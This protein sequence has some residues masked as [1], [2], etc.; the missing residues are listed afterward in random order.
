MAEKE[1]NI[2]SAVEGLDEQRRETLKRLIRGGAFVAPVVA[3]FAMQGVSIR[4]AHAASSAVSNGTGI[5][6]SDVR[7]KRDVVR[8]ETHTNG[9]GIFSF[10]YLWS[11]TNYVGAIAQ[12]VLERAPDAVVVGPGGFL[13]VDYEALDMTMRPEAERAY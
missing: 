2:E 12:D 10:R 1:R 8:L 11:D 13:A 6:L 5:Q 4:P 9:C 3:S 7:L